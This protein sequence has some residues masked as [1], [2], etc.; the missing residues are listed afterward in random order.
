MGI[1]SS[2]SSFDLF[3]FRINLKIWILQTVGRTPLMGDQ[4]VARPLPTQD[5]TNTEKN[6]NMARVG[7]ELTIAVFERAKEFLA[8]H[9]TAAVIIV[10][11][12]PVSLNGPCSMLC[13]SGS[14]WH[15]YIFKVCVMRH[16]FCRTC[17]W[18]TDLKL[19]IHNAVRYSSEVC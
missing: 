4:P 1:I 11:T 16:Y 12:C 13:C 14:I 19:A 6:A 5:R 10:L 15:L 8:I 2:S 3:T 17:F 7:S 9:G 18:V